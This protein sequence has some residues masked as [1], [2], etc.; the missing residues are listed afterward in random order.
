MSLAVGH[1]LIRAY[2]SKRVWLSPDAEHVFRTLQE[3]LSAPTLPHDTAT[4]VEEQSNSR[5]IPQ[6]HDKTIPVCPFQLA[7]IH[8]KLKLYFSLPHHTHAGTLTRGSKIQFPL[9]AA[10]SLLVRHAIRAPQT[11]LRR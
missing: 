11:A 4:S 1:I 6:P 3:D 8:H 10:Y 9:A 5:V 2:Y 7:A